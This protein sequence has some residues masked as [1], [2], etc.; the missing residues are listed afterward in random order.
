MPSRTEELDPV[1]LFAALCLFFAS[2]EYAIPKPLPFMKLGL[3]N[4]PILLALEVLSSRLVLLLVFLKVL[5]QGL[6]HGTLFTYVFLLS[7]GGSLAS[8]AVMILIKRSLSRNAGLVGVSVMGALTN[9]IVQILLARYLVFGEQAWLIAPPFLVVGTV[10]STL[11]GMLAQRF[12]S[13][14]HWLAS[15]VRTR[16]QES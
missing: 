5:A 10:S 4:L 9:N 15:V 11:L 8:G 14:S 3:A 13:H 1:A 12:S 16:N 2:L 7:F 6:I